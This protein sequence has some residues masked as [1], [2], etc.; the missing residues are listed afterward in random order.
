ML[1]PVRLRDRGEYNLFMAIVSLGYAKEQADYLSMFNETRAND[2]QLTAEDKYRLCSSGLFQL[3]ES[4][5]SVIARKPD[6]LGIASDS[7]EDPVRKY[8][9]KFVD[10]RN[11]IGHQNI[12][13][14]QGRILR[15]SKKF[16]PEAKDRIDY[17]ISTL[18]FPRIS[19]AGKYSEG[20]QKIYYRI[21]N[22]KA[23]LNNPKIQE[24]GF[25]PAPISDSHVTKLQ[26][27]INSFTFGSS[28]RR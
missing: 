23:R 17:A 14:L 1:E 5:H 6:L 11:L 24:G 19:S 10:V 16:I 8:W 20:R 26:D 27:S 9:D 2:K 15:F 4:I 7:R 25:R 12:D 21:I 18:S 3:G 22:W 13:L 28:R